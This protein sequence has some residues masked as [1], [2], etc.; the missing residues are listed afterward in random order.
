M[1]TNKPAKKRLSTS[2]KILVAILILLVLLYQYLA[3]MGIGNTV[4]LLRLLVLAPNS[5]SSSFFVA[6]EGAFAAYLLAFS[7]RTGRGI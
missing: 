4:P 3:S 2:K 6:A 1:E 7:I 5:S